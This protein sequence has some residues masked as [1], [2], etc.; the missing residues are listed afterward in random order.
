MGMVD[1]DDQSHEPEE[2]EDKEMA[3]DNEEEGQDDRRSAPEEPNDPAAVDDEPASQDPGKLTSPSKQP[4]QGESTTSPS[5]K[6]D[7]KCGCV[8]NLPDPSQPGPSSSFSKARKGDMG[9]SDGLHLNSS[10]L[11]KLGH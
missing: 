10:D 9:E 7:N 5:S 11:K 1:G 3:D 2:D 6:L 4:H 8:A